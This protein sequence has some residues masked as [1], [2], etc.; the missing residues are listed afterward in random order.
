MVQWVK[1]LAAKSEDPSLIPTTHVVEGEKQLPQVVLC[2]LHLHHAH[3]WKKNIFG[4]EAGLFVLR[5][6]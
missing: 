4:A 1:A 2:F 6:L 5:A 3:E